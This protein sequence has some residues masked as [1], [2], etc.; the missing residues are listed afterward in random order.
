MYGEDEGC[1]NDS[2]DIAA[3]EPAQSLDEYGRLYN[4]NAVEDARGLCQSGW[5]VPEYEAFSELVEHLDGFDVAGT[6]MKTTYG[7]STFNEGGNG[8]NSSGFSGLPGGFRSGSNGYYYISGRT[9]MWW[10]STA[11]SEVGGD[12]GGWYWN[13][14]SQNGFALPYVFADFDTAG[15]SI[16]CIKD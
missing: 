5:H 6:A 2:P 9:G 14:E 8:T 1:D 7:W 4:W 15:L 3:C 11:Y 10:S 12:L 16:R 13:V